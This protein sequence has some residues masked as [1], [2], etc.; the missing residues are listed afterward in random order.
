MVHLPTASPR[1]RC[2]QRP[3]RA[4]AAAACAAAAALL[5]GCG[6]ASSTGSAGP[7]KPLSPRQAI[8]LAYDTTSRATSVT[9]DF[10]IQA[11]TSPGEGLTGTM[12]ERL[13]PT[14]LLAEHL[15]L[16]AAGQKVAISEILSAQAIYLKEAAMSTESGKPW[17]E[18]PLSSLSGGLGG[19]LTQLLQD[20]Q[21]GNP[22]EQTQVLATAKD[23]RADGTQVV[24]G[25]QT[26]RY[27]G[28]IS[29]AAA[30]KAISPSL[31]TS[32]APMLNLISGDITFTVSI[33]G[34]HQVRRL[35]ESETASGERINVTMNITSVNQPVHITLPPASQVATIPQADLGDL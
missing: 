29:P 16:S 19:V 24:D 25:V 27:A 32:L 14:L 28:S 34:Q 33:D 1:N 8:T 2:G 22:L 4:A 12:S 31:R 15:S 13:K 23:V 35:V 17:V 11:G 21:N 18:I 6:A 20:V 7:A 30:L 3:W 26:T 5:A 9:G 10:T